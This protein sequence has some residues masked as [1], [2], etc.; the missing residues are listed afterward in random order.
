MSLLNSFTAVKSQF[1]FF[2]A[3]IL[4]NGN[5][6][7]SEQNSENESISLDLSAKNV[8][9]FLQISP[10]KHSVTIHVA[11]HMLKDVQR[12]LDNDLNFIRSHFQC[13]NI[14]KTVSNSDIIFGGNDIS[15]DKSLKEIEKDDASLPWA[16]RSYRNKA[17]SIIVSGL[18]QRNDVK[19]VQGKGSPRK[20]VST[21]WI[22]F[23]RQY[24]MYM[25][26]SFSQNKGF[27]THDGIHFNSRETSRYI[28]TINNIVGILNYH[29]DVCAHYVELNH[30]TS[31]C[32]FGKKIK[33]HKCNM[34]GHKLK[35]CKA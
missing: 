18:P 12:I 30:K 29:S 25:S 26:D 17:C 4:F 21:F 7:S 24:E 11:Q 5:S 35:V 10:K 16:A 13:G 15:A 33:C 19:C 9:D 6:E 1:N 27:Y 28:K 14:Y 2:N 20:T 8:P 22:G 31:S 32:R 23:I 3:T 34:Y